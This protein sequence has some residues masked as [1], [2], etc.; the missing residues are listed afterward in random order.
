MS[1]RTV[2]VAD[3]H[4]LFREGLIALLSRDDRVSI[5]GQA[6]DGESAVE[7][8][9]R[10]RPD[11]LLLDVSMPGMPCPATIAAVRRSSSVTR[12]IVLTMHADPILRATLIQAGAAD[13]LSKA[14][15]SARLI[16]SIVEPVTGGDTGALDP[17]PARVTAREGEILQLA[18]LA[19]SNREIAAAL[20]I[21]EGTVKRH[22]H[23]VS[24]KLGATSRLDAAR[25]AA[26]LGIITL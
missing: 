2:A 25:K 21:A 1:A 7:L 5:V 14:V 22:L 20:N 18:A 17:L 19:F 15:P 11:V 6:S 9:A 26:R 4:L 16:G 3:D 12:V 23:N 13:Y 8:V 24:E 10:T